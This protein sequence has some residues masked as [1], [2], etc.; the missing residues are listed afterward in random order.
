MKARGNSGDVQLARRFEEFPLPRWSAEEGFEQ[1]VLAIIRNLPLPATNGSL[2]PRRRKILQV[3]DGIITS[4]S[5]A[6]NDLAIEAMRAAERVLDDAIERCRPDRSATKWPSLQTMPFPVVLPA[7]PDELLSSWLQRHA[8]FY[9]V[10]GGRL[11]ALRPGRGVV[12]KPGPH[13]D[14]LRHNW[15]MRSGAGYSGR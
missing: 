2:G 4:R 14:C 15:R 7:L 3:T 1:L 9:G 10:S 12:A 5:S 8:N 11:L 6:L 13:P